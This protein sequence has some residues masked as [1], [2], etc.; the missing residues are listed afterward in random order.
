MWLKPR[1]RNTEK[2]ISRCLCVCVCVRALRRVYLHDERLLLPTN[3]HQPQ[4]NGKIAGFP[5]PSRES[6]PPS[7]LCSSITPTSSRS[8]GSVPGLSLP[9]PGSL[10]IYWFPDWS[11]FTVDVVWAPASSPCLSS[12]LLSLPLPL[13]VTGFSFTL[14]VFLL[15][16]F[17]IAQTQWG[18]EEQLWKTWKRERCCCSSS[19]W[20]LGAPSVCDS[21]GTKECDVYVKQRLKVLVRKKQ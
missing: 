3:R 6:C 15:H 16:E 14:L 18:A 20:T 8:H 10:L 12:L 1:K 21:Q 5:A 13:S 19:V 4:H 7:P 11:L 17:L 2:L 9:P